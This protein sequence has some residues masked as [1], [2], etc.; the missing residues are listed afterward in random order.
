M[1]HSKRQIRTVQ[2]LKGIADNALC[3]LNESQAAGSTVCRTTV[4]LVELYSVFPFCRSNF[5]CLE[6]INQRLWKL[7][8]AHSLKC[9]MTF[10]ILSK[11][12]DSTWKYKCTY[13]WTATTGCKTIVWLQCDANCQHS[14]HSW[15]WLHACQ[16]HFF[17]SMHVQASLSACQILGSATVCNIAMTQWLAKSSAS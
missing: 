14:Q 9:V 15:L 10:A 17:S 8:C 13:I 3:V 7:D 6:R 2:A 5:R 16:L 4:V 1:A 11:K 12:K